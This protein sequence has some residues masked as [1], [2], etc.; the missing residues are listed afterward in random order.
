[1]KLPISHLVFSRRALEANNI[2]H[3]RVFTEKCVCAIPDG[4]Y[5]RTEKVYQLSRMFYAMQV[6]S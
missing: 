2:I 5:Q 4:T 3:Y 6:T 1:V